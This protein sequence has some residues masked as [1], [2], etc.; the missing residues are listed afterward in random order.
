ML[1]V[2]LGVEFSGTTLTSELIHHSG[3]RMIDEESDSYDLGG[4]Y[5]HP[6]F[7]QINK[8]I[9]KLTDDTVYHLRVSDCPEVLQQP[10][11]DQMLN[12]IKRQTKKNDDWGFKD[13]RS[14]VTYPLWHHLLPQHRVIA[15]YRNPAGNWPRHRW[16]GLRKRYSNPWR[17]Y[18]HLRQ[19]YEYN[20]AI[21]T[22]GSKLGD[23]FLLLNYEKLMQSDAEISRLQAFLGKQLKDMRKAGMHRSRTQGDILFRCVQWLMKF[24]VYSPIRML[25][26][27]EAARSAQCRG[28]KKDNT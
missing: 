6:A 4:K 23:D 15:I 7:Q 19:W 5:E 20:E 25:N 11:K 28:F 22:N 10:Q 1:Y 8:D 3:V 17:A 16:R 26:R 24:G 14:V 21:L 27:L 2:V 18:V 13:P 9:L 12:L